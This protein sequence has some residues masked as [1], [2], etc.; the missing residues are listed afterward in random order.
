MG[1]RQAYIDQLEDL[2]PGGIRRPLTQVIKDCLRN[3]P[4]QRPTAEQ[5][6][7][8]LDEM[9]LV[10]EGDYGE[11]ATVDAVRRV[12]TMK[13]LKSRSDDKINELAAKDE[14]MQQLQ[15]QLAVRLLIIQYL[16]SRK[17]LLVHYILQQVIH[18]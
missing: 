4:A 12:R 8:A 10:I 6:V 2:L 13:A 15:Q 5:L 1:R 11:L 7:T 9:K 18:L 16:F 14:Q 3:V 17:S